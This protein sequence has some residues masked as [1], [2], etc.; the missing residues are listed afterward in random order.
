MLASDNFEC[1]EIDDYLN[2]GQAL[3]ALPSPQILEGQVPPVSQCG[4]NLDMGQ[5][6]WTSIGGEHP[7]TIQEAQ[8]FAHMNNNSTGSECNRI[9]PLPR[10]T[11]ENDP[12]LSCNIPRTPGGMTDV[13][14]KD[15]AWFR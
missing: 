4:A 13:D 5:S 12:M 7:F 3:M 6:S 11:S 10:T 1:L 2:Q 14:E 15:D 8:K 9:S